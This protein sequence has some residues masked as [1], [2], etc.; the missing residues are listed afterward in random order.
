ME[1]ETT[2]LGLMLKTVVSVSFQITFIIESEEGG[3]FYL[4]YYKWIQIF[5][6]ETIE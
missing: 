5:A 2:M 1:M 6:L 3:F 4:F